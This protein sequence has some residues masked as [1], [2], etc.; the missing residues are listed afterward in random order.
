[1]GDKADDCAT[2]IPFRANSRDI[3]DHALTLGLERS[4][5]SESA[6]KEWSMGILRLDRFA[7]R[8][9]VRGTS[10]DYEGYWRSP[11]LQPQQTAPQLCRRK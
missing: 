8:S 9:P 11:H 10:L 4:P 2:L 6:Y 3:A 7:R 5:C 1:M